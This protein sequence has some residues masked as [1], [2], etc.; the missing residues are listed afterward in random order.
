M[1][2]ACERGQLRRRKTW[3]N[4]TCD[5]QK[6]NKII[7]RK[8]RN[9]SPLRGTA[10]LLFSTTSRRRTNL[11]GLVTQLQQRKTYATC[12]Q[13]AVL[14]TYPRASISQFH[15]FTSPAEGMWNIQEK[16]MSE[17]SNGSL[18][19]KIR[20]NGT[21]KIKFGTQIPVYIVMLTERHSNR[22]A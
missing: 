1:C 21:I 7:C 5:T 12:I 18:V 3:R 10:S 8:W 20:T 16:M 15:Y 14:W 19:Q 4:F 9:A 22:S 6:G 13:N 2:T 11:T 17:T